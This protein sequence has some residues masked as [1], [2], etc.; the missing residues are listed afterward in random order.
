MQIYQLFVGRHETANIRDHLGHVFEQMLSWNF[1]IL[2]ESGFDVVY[3][4]G[5]FDYTGP[6]IVSEEDREPLEAEGHDRVPSLFAV[7]DHRK[8]WPDL[9]TINQLKQLIDSIHAS[10]LRVWLD[11]IPN[12]TS[13]VHP[14]V[15]EHPEYYQGHE[16][17]FSRAFSQDVYLLDHMHS[18]VL[19]EMKQTLAT[20]FDWGI[21]GVRCDMAHLAPPTFWQEMIGY[22]REK[23]N[24]FTFAAEVYGESVFD[25]SPLSVL[26]KAGFDY[27]YHEFLYRNL[28]HSVNLGLEGLV[29]HLTYV[30]NSPYLS[31][32]IHYGSNHDDPIPSGL[33]Q[34]IEALVCLFRVMGGSTLIYNGSLRG[35]ARRLTHHTL[36]IL[37]RDQCELWFIPDWYRNC[38][39]LVKTVPLISIQITLL[40]P[41]IIQV[42]GLT[43]AHQQIIWWFHLG[44][45]DVSCSID[46]EGLLHGT[47]LGDIVTVGQAEVW[48]MPTVRESR[49]S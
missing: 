18:G 44:A 5:V 47:V 31:E 45:E 17:G 37:P 4:L 33:E 3:L 12:Q 11:F 14:W 35:F 15:N 26:F 10:G 43:E 7:S 13:T 28:K 46:G 32:L 2:H 22:A 16:S 8:P 23:Q 25:W 36:D 40:D 38:Q 6:I 42:T 30:V 20:I 29:G 41:G 39:M 19:E 48:L 21:D 49:E 1:Q 24:R 34:K 9:G 27:C